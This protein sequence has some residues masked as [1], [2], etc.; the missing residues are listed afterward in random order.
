MRPL[1]YGSGKGTGDSRTWTEPKGF[2]EA[3]P[4]RKRKETDV[5]PALGDAAGFNEA[6]PLRKRKGLVKPFAAKAFLELQ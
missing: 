2:N 6:A 1:P 3:A 4:L 5:F